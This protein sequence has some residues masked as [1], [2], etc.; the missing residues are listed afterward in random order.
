MTPASHPTATPPKQS[1][2]WRRHLLAALSAGMLLAMPG[3]ATA[4]ADQ[5]LTGL[6]PKDRQIGSDAHAQIVQEFG[7]QL[8]GPLSAYVRQVALKVALAS[9]PGS[10][11]EDWTVTVLDSPVPNAMATPGGYLYITRGLLAMINN[12]AELASVLGHEAGHVAARHSNKRNSRA[13]IG[14]L[15]SIA[16]SI[17]LG[18]DAASL[19]NTGA[20]ALIAGYS[21]GQEREADTLGMQY[22]MQ[23]GYDP[24]AAATMLAALDRVGAVEGRDSFEQRGA[25]SIFS[26]HPVTAER[27]QRVSAQ[28]R[29][30]GRSGATNTAAFLS[31]IDGMTFGE[32][33]DQ[34][35]IS[36]TSFRHASLRLGFDAPAGFTLQNSPQA[37]TGQA[38]DGSQFIFTGATAQAGQSL[39]D[40]VNTVWRQTAGQLPQASTA[41]RRISELDAIISSAT[42]RNNRNQNVD[43]GVNAFR[44]AENQ[45]YVLRTMAPAGRGQQLQSMVNSFRRL[46]AAEVRAA[47]SGLR[48]RVVTVASGDTA[49][50]LTSRMAAPYN[51]VDSFLALNGLTRDGVRT[52]TAV[53]LI[54]N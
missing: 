26:T 3:C 37:V 31:A 27:V 53:K 10:R 21:R 11:P 2:K 54:T 5:G 16:A 9:V 19:V 39:H 48:I 15:G 30:T 43:I 23:A 38:R 41:E 49:D 51:R 36:G 25:V 1:P 33:P 18:G 32:S 35:L 22:A 17:L 52:G 12:E 4:A 24:N 6:S 8:S 14:A 20:S 47:S 50:S 34:G 28:A 29:Q 42:L 44:T 13:T 40:I 7:G 46:N 45:I